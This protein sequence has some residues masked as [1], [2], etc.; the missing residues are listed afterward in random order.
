ML[1]MGPL[2]A[3]VD[4]L[5]QTTLSTVA[6]ALLALAF[7]RNRANVRYWL[8]LAA[9]MKF[10]V[11]F[12]A[13][14]A[15]GG[16]LNWGPALPAAPPELARALEAV[17]QPFT[18]PA[19]ATVGASVT[20]TPDGDG[21]LVAALAVIWLVGCVTLF[22][23]W[24]F[25]WRRMSTLAATAAPITSGPVPAALHR[26]EAIAG[27]TRP[28]AVVASTAS[29]EPGVFGIR[30]PVLLWPPGIDTRLSDAQVEGILAH[31]VA[32]VR[33]RDNLTATLHMV[34]E[35]LFWFHPLVWW[36]G[37]RLVDERERASDEDVVR[38]G[39]EPH[40]YAEGILR[41]CQ[42]YIESPLACVAGVTGSDLKRRIE[43]IMKN[44]SHVRLST[45]KRAL[46]ACA[47]L[48]ALMGPVALGVVSEERL[49]RRPRHSFRLRPMPRCLTPH[50]SDQTTVAAG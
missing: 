18:L 43:A 6:V 3:F 21:S 23:T 1:T 11:P 8:W 19:F 7:R 10:L 49:G 33:R 22:G 41:T 37:A 46:L 17:S 30:R 4:H 26:L 40:V 50:Q 5:W 12:A 28:I 15:L 32:H 29:I 13:L 45:W 36:I 25:Q 20:A 34:V 24:L 27:L 39:T 9:S 2:D 31:E 38:L 48:T 35:A 42:F 44:E 16:M 14:T 47:S